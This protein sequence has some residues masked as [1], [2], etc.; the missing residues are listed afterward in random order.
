MIE[1][2]LLHKRFANKAVASAEDLRVWLAEAQ[3]PEFAKLAASDD[4][5]SRWSARQQIGRIKA[6]DL[7]KLAS[8]YKDAS[9]AEKASEAFEQKLARLDQSAAKV[10]E[11]NLQW[12]MK[13]RPEITSAIAQIDQEIAR[14]ADELRGAAAKRQNE[15]EQIALRKAAEMKQ[16]QEAMEFAGKLETMKVSAVS[17]VQNEWQ[18]R[19]KGIADEIRSDATRFNPAV[20]ERVAGIRQK[21]EIVDGA[22][23]ALP[24]RL[25]LKAGSAAWN[26]RLIAAL[27]SLD[28]KQRERMV[29]ELVA[30]SR[31]LTIEDLKGRADESRKR[32]ENWSGAAA[33]LVTDLNE[34]DRL[35]ALGYSPDERPAREILENWQKQDWFTSDLVQSAIEPLLAPIR[36]L[37]RADGQRLLRLAA[38]SEHRLG[39]RLMAW[40]KLGEA[41][42]AWPAEQEDL[43]QAVG[44]SDSL[45]AAVEKEVPQDR[46]EILRTKVGRATGKLWYRFVA[47]ASKAEDITVA[48]GLREKLAISLEMLDS[49]MRFNAAVYDARR[50]HG[51]DE[52]ATSG[53][54]V[55]LQSAIDA[56]PAGVRDSREIADLATALRQSRAG[57]Q[58]VDFSTLG[59][60]ARRARDG[61]PI[62]WQPKYDQASDTVSYTAQVSPEITSEELE[63][64]FKR[65]ETESGDVYLSTTEVSVGLF[66]DVI[67]AANRWRDV[68]QMMWSYGSRGDPRL[69]PRSWEWPKYGPGIWKTKY[70]LAES[71]EH[72]PP[73]L[74]TA[75]N[76]AVL[77]DKNGLP[78]RELNPSK[79]QPMQYVS[80]QAA[81][82]FCDLLS[83]RLPTSGEWKAAYRLYANDHPNLRDK[84]FKTFQRWNY[85][86]DL[87]NFISAGEK[88]TTEIW[89][90]S[91]VSSRGPDNDLEY[92]DGALWFTEVAPAGMRVFNHLVGNVAE[93]TLENGNLY[94]IGGSALSPPTRAVN[95]ECE[96]LG[97]RGGN[98]GYS[99]V[100]F[101]LAFSGPANARQQLIAALEKQTYLLP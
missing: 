79:R 87:G 90:E 31:E 99:D 32:Y 84:T 60:T 19:S 47:R 8:L 51:S 33:K 56:L 25:E 5:R 43:K 70:W 46:R 96:M 66:A 3:H 10:L 26:E 67:T 52:R 37:G 94:V 44:I 35:L 81:N 97:W 77:K 68:A 6:N 27:G 80:P 91:K 93:M 55:S 22:L 38:A 4:P 13:N 40:E 69:G 63:I 71:G 30:A 57:A 7:A 58:R 9:E 24:E 41:A 61:N 83:C 82:Y 85:M 49:R 76:R 65:V 98:K 62:N 36:V 2:S 75:D 16:R 45:L 64:V 92:D 101:R 48:L 39:L 88:Q 73:S 42:V 17:V 72:Y 50:M 54:T 95:R 21:L 29:E 89:A 15:L 59:P 23:R 20:A 86:P 12:S 14:T 74:A 78:A 100:G 18:A 53:V 11:S 28:L 34:V 1:S